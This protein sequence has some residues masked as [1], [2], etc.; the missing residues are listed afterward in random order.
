MR[1]FTGIFFTIFVPVTLVLMLTL[2]YSGRLAE[3]AELRSREAAG[4]SPAFSQK[5][6]SADT[7]HNRKALDYNFR[8]LLLSVATSGLIS[9]LLA[10]QNFC[11][12]A[13]ACRYSRQD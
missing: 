7:E 6:D 4:R 9:F 12:D 11:S 13:E 8:L 1:L 3:D 5:S 2:H 10:G